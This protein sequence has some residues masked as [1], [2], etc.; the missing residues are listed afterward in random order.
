MHG[1][2]LGACPKGH[3]RTGSYDVG[4]KTLDKYFVSKKHI[5]AGM[6]VHDWQN[7]DA[8]W[9]PYIGVKDISKAI[10]KIYEAGG[11]LLVKAGKSAVIDD[12]TGAAIILI[13]AT[14]DAHID[15]GILWPFSHIQTNPKT[16]ST[17]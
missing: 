3:C 7:L 5:R 11:T 10:L 14:A 15:N 1:A 16:I 4:N 2:L 9:L 6:V 17:C 8:N 13:P 12:V